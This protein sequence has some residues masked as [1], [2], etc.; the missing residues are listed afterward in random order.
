MYKGILFKV[1]LA[2]FSVTKPVS[3]SVQPPVFSPSVATSFSSDVSSRYPDTNDLLKI[4]SGLEK[5]H[6][7]STRL[8]EELIA[9]ASRVSSQSNNMII[10]R[11][12]YLHEKYLY[13]KY[14]S[15]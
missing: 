15:P 7:D 11:N 8:A 5:T 1:P 9:S 3:P 14:L 4:A 13:E 6:T 10:F 2:F 12:V